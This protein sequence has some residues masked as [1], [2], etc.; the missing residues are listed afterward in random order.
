MNIV[1]NGTVDVVYV[2]ITKRYSARYS[3]HTRSGGEYPRSKY[4]ML[5]IATELSKEQA[6]DMEQLIITAYTLDSLKNS[7]NSIAKKNWWLF[8]REFKQIITLMES[9]VDPE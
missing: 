6:R 7:I 3:Y 2:G 4:T 5:P 1:R 9:W 8:L